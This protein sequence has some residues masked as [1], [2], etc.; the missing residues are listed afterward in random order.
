MRELQGVCNR[1]DIQLTRP[2]L[3]YNTLHALQAI[4][5]YA[6]IVHQTNI[7]NSNGVLVITLLIPNSNPTWR[8]ILS[9]YR[10][11]DLIEESN[12][13]SLKHTSWD[14]AHWFG[15]DLLIARGVERIQASVRLTLIAHEIV[16]RFSIDSWIYTIYMFE[17][18]LWNSG[19]WKVVAAGRIKEP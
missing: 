13:F 4:L 8:N 15:I 16:S 18:P 11:S 14:R 19:K 1:R 5:V 7:S 9:W 17:N 2:A 6:V 10:N 12:R 3:Q